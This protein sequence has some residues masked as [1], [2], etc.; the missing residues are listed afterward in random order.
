MGSP[1]SDPVMSA[2]PGRPA[3]LVRAVTAASEALL[4]SN[5]HGYITEE[6][7]PELARVAVEAAAPIL[8]GM[9]RDLEAAGENLTE[10][11]RTDG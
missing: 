10:L 5:H 11:E 1:N 2:T 9:G 4:D 7:A 6:W 8:I 3:E